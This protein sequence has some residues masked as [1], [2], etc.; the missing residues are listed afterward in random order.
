VVLNRVLIKVDLPR[1]DSPGVHVQV[2]REH[3]QWRKRTDDHT[4]EL[5]TFPNALPVYLIREVGKPNVAHQL[6]A[7]DG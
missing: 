7:D 3:E 5:E 6:F 1:P 4:C 2:E